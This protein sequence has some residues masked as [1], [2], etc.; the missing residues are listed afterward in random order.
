[1]V[2]P[3]TALFFG[4]GNQVGS[5]DVAVAGRL[6]LLSAAAVALLQ[7]VLLP[8]L[9]RLLSTDATTDLHCNRCGRC[10]SLQTPH[11][12]AAIVARVF[13]DPQLRCGS[14]LGAAGWLHARA[15]WHRCQRTCLC[16]HYTGLH[17]VAAAGPLFVAGCSSTRPSGCW[18]RCPPCSPSPSCPPSSALLPIAYRPLCAQVGCS[19]WHGQRGGPALL[20]A[21]QQQHWQSYSSCAVTMLLLISLQ[22]RVWQVCS[23]ALVA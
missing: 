18:T 10:C 15:A 23:A 5:S 16:V 8:L 6:P 21:R 3:L 12:S 4:T 14:R 20:L 19:A 1:M 11:V 17:L 13:L 2:F 22:A 9:Q 7:A